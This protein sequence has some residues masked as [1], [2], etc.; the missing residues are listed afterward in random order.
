MTSFDESS[1]PGQPAS[2]A[3]R[4]GDRSADP[5][6]CSQIDFDLGFY[7]HVLQREPAYVDV[8]RCQAALLTRKGQYHQALE[9]DRRLVELVPDDAVVRYNL[10]CSLART[11]ERLDAITALRESFERGYDDFEH[12]LADSDLDL[13]RDDPAFQKLLNQYQLADDATVNDER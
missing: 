3:G 13:L 1:E 2:T 4:R 10:A 6:E 8:L 5:G 9:M 12:L 11:G 7:D